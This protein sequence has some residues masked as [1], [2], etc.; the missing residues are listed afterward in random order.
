MGEHQ[1]GDHPVHRVQRGTQEHGG[2]HI[3][4]PLSHSRSVGTGGGKGGSCCIFD[5]SPTLSLLRH[6]DHVRTRERA[7][8]RNLSGQ[9]SARWRYKTEQRD[10]SLS[11]LWRCR[12]LEHCDVDAR[13]RCFFSYDRQAFIRAKYADRKF[14]LPLPSAGDPPQNQGRVLTRWTVGRRD[15]TSS[16]SQVR[17]LDQTIAVCWTFDDDRVEDHD[18]TSPGHFRIATACGD[19]TC[20]HRSAI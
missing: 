16:G 18:L 15:M 8:K 5:A 17:T 2:P 7:S 9:A 13:S 1:S 6:A 12:T 3:E 20:L 19:L 14:V 10:V 11:S 4:G